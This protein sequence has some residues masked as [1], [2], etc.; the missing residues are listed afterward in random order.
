M[1]EMHKMF[2]TW[3]GSLH[4]SG[5]A[6]ETK[7]SEWWSACEAQVADS[8]VAEVIGLVRI[9]FG[10]PEAGFDTQW[11]TVVA[12]HDQLFPLKGGDQK[13]SVVA[14]AAVMLA[15]ESPKLGPATQ[16]ARLCA[17]RAGWTPSIDDLAGD[18]ATLRALAASRRVVSTWPRRNPITL[19]LASAKEPITV[20]ID[21]G[22]AAITPDV[23]SRVVGALGTAA[24]ASLAKVL[25]RVQDLTIKREL[26]LR[27]QSDVL[28]WLMRGRSTVLDL[29]WSDLSQLDAAIAAAVELNSLSRFDVGRED[30]S[31]LIKFKVASAGKKSKANPDQVCDVVTSNDDLAKL[32]PVRMAILDGTLSENLEPED[33]GL[34]LHDELNLA[35][36][37]QG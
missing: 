6:D 32:A 18:A 23:L 31:A 26:P 3:V 2:A 4:S 15:S 17:T 7:V 37:L 35:R 25:T 27:E 5:D 10:R 22:A 14:A 36:L 33:V 16:L 13:V 24:D 11:R 21:E 19:D 12:E 1:A 20:A 30:A 8:G 28:V 34:Q 9:A 29:A